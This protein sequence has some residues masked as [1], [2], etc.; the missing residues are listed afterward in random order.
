MDALGFDPEDFEADAVE[1][2]PENWPAFD[3]FC[4]L[5][6]QWRT[7]MSG[8]TGLDYTATLACIA[9]LHGDLTPADRADLFRDL[10]AMEA[11]ALSELARKD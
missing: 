9:A 11:A 8:P 10:R 1:I 5:G 4:T 2:W 3:L 6:T 7:G